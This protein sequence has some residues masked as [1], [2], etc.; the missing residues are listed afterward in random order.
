M[1]FGIRVTFIRNAT[2]DAIIVPINNSSK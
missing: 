1:N 2:T